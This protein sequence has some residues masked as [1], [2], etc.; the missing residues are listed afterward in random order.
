VKNL[1]LHQE[2]RD[3]MSNAFAPV[4]VYLSFWR[5]SVEAGS[6][7]SLQIMLVNDEDHEVEGTLAVALE[8]A[9]SERVSSQTKQ[10]KIAA[11]GQS[12][13]YSDFKFPS[14][15]GDFLLRAIIEYGDGIS[16]QSRRHV[17]VG[18]GTH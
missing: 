2:F 1:E 15:T 5:P 13:I 10:F 8:D 14:A 11:L 6:L 3:Y 4:G 9:K 7:Q 12:T 18:A 17:K 16:T